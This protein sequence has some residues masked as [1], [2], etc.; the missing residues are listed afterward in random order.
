MKV[1]K[2]AFK[3]FMITVLAVSGAMLGL[4][5]LCVIYGMVFY[6]YDP[7]TMFEAIKQDLEAIFG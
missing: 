2:T 5:A 6:D 4:F 1:D 7:M 3:D